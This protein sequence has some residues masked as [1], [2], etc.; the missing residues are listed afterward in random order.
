M[1]VRIPLADI[2]V[3]QARTLRKD[4]DSYAIYRRSVEQLEELYG[5]LEDSKASEKLAFVLIIL[6]QRYGSTHNL[7]GL[8]ELHRSLVGRRNVLVPLSSKSELSPREWLILFAATQMAR[9]L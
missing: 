5:F 2:I 7:K 8:R 4:P 3:A 9:R 6:T 1:G